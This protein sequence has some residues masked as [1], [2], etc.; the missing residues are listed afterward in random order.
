MKQCTRRIRAGAAIADISPKLGVQLEGYPPETRQNTGIHDPLYASCLYLDDEQTKLVIICVDIV[1]FEKPFATTVR[2]SIAQQLA[3][4][5]ANVMLSA[6]HTHSGPRTRSWLDAEDKARGY[7]ICPE[8]MATLENKL[9][10]LAL[11]ACKKA[12]KAKIGFGSGSAGKK[13]GIGGNRHD[14]NGLCDPTVGVIGVQDACGKWIACLVKYSLH[15]AILQADNL[16]VS[17]DFPCYIRK[18]LNHSKPTSIILF[19]QGSTGDQSSRYFRNGQTF[20]EAERFGEVIGKEADRVLNSLAMNDYV[21]L[22]ALS[23]EIMP[24]LRELPTIREAQA[25]VN[26]YQK[27]MENL[28]AADAPYVDIQ[29]CSRNLLGAEFT[30][31]YAKYKAKGKVYPWAKSEFPMEIQALQIGNCCLV[32]LPGEIFVKYTLEIEK[33]SP[34]DNTFV[35]TCANGYL[36]GYVVTEEAAE[37]NLFE[38]GTSLMKPK[39]GQMMVAAA[40]QLFEEM[41]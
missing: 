23:T 35:V 39:T 38:A 16:L 27:E 30:L 21:P 40:G 11:N 31:C 26:R 3:I 17:A 24:E 20:E 37:K 14:P 9:V 1:Y 18:Y 10:A 5:P 13:Q 4:P 33:A 15:P 19:A 41:K 6:S 36:P 7:E 2:N 28:Q 34:F 29:T 8:Y 22:R 32:G 25:I 12:A